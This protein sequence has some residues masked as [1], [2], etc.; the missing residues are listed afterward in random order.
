[1]N[2]RSRR[3]TRTE[4]AVTSLSTVDVLMLLNILVFNLLYSEKTYDIDTK[5]ATTKSNIGYSLLLFFG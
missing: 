5:D 1:M 2:A 4:G 3:A